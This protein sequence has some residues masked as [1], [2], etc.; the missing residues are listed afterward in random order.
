M[1][2]ATANWGRIFVIRLEDGEIVHEVLENFAR[3]HSIKAAAL[4]ILGGADTG[5]RIV[6]GPE[7]GRSEIIVPMEHIL[8]NVHEVA[9]TGTLF[10][11]EE[12]NPLLHMH[13]AFGRKTAALT[14]CVRA[15]V[16]VWQVMEVVLFEL[17]GTGAVRR[18]DAATG[19]KLLDPGAR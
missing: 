8:E 7:E 10:P 4:V 5:S 2:Y 15:G 12:G 11:D 9:G 6:T 1:K 3:E 14:G 13:M 18:L 17:E 19:F 16:K